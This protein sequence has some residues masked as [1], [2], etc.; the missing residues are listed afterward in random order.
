MAMGRGPS[1]PG[2]PGKLKLFLSEPKMHKTSTE[3]SETYSYVIA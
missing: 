1:V 3:W 2:G